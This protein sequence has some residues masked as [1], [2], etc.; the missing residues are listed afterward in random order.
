MKILIADDNDAMRRHISFALE[1]QGHEVLLTKDGEE[2]WTELQ[3]ASAPNMA[4]LDWN[5]PVL[6]GP[7]I[8]KRLREKEKDKPKYLILLTVRNRSEE[9]AAGLDAGANDYIVKPFDFEELRA[10]I[11]VGKRVIELQQSLSKR[12]VELQEALDH[13]KKLQGLLPICMHCHKIK[14][15]QKTWQKLEA[16]I[17][18]HS[19]A[20]LSHGLCPDCLKKYYPEYSSINFDDTEE[21]Q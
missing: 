13:V 4:I 18:E 3:R 21:S 15:D 17:H 5:M 6:D 9:I 16:Y 8:C 2:A 7:E 11:S 10:R 20:K 12:V 19:E 1:E 14:N